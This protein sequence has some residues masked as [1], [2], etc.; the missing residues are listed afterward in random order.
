MIS[1]FISCFLGL[2]LLLLLLEPSWGHRCLR[3]RVP[4]LTSVPP[5]HWNS[6]VF[7]ALV[8]AVAKRSLSIPMV[9]WYSVGLSVE[10]A[11]VVVSPTGGRRILR[12]VGVHNRDTCNCGI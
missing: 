5:G 6:H 3:R 8:G 11:P 9:P 2:L 7:K 10:I 12:L 4:G 1:V